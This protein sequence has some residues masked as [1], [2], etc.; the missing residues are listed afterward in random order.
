M[1]FTLGHKW[2]RPEPPIDKGLL[3]K[4][5]IGFLQR[6]GS[7]QIHQRHFNHGLKTLLQF[8]LVGIRD[9]SNV[10]HTLNG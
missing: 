2:Q 9:K 6:P 3:T 5:A 10:T 7:P 1:M 4:L 8:G